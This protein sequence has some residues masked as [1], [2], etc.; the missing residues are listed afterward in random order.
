MDIS[1]SKYFYIDTFQNYH[2]YILTEK[3]K[4]TQLIIF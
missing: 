4:S 2:I 1:F 3:F